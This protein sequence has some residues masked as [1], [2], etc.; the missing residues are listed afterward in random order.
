MQ[1]VLEDERAKGARSMDRFLVYCINLVKLY[2]KKEAWVLHSAKKN[3]ETLPKKKTG[4]LIIT[5]NY[6]EVF[7]DFQ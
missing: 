5:K 2:H 7:N 3:G 4:I 1:D 6:F